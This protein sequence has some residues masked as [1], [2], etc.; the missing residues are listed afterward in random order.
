MG[1]GATPGQDNRRGCEDEEES[2]NL[3]LPL[4]TIITSSHWKLKACHIDKKISEPT[5][6]DSLV[7]VYFLRLYDWGVLSP[8]KI[9]P[10]NAEGDGK[11]APQ[12]IS[13][14]SAPRRWATLSA[15]STPLKRKVDQALKTLS[16]ET[17][18]LINDFH[19]FKP[20]H[21]AMHALHVIINPASRGLTSW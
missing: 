20:G 11:D 12:N 7:Q 5:A 2:K 6:L 15:K 8:G 3:M 19:L 21:L 17:R 14:E 13:N 18:I 16:S 1:L 9:T 10:N 4:T